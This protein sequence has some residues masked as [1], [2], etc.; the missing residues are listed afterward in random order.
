MDQRPP[1]HAAPETY[2]IRTGASG[3]ELSTQFD[4]LRLATATI[5]TVAIPLAWDAEFIEMNQEAGPMLT[6]DLGNPML[7]PTALSRIGTFF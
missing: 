4:F 1:A 5:F 7:R 3:P 6:A 2:V